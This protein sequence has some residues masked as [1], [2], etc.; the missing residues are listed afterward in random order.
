MASLRRLAGTLAAI[1]QTRIELL[2]VEVEDQVLRVW[3]LVLLAA[4]VLLFSGLALIFFS[5]WLVALFWETHPVAALGG[6]T[7]A[8]LCAAV[9]AAQVFRYRR[10]TRPKLFAAS[11]A[12]LA[13]DREHLAP[14]PP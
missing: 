14:P 5:A 4:A 13:R 7:I 8:Y 9:F 1:V 10:R 11:L 6:L 12:E 2:S 3:Q